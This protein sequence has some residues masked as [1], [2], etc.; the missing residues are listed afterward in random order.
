MLK[1]YEE[2]IESG[3][4]KLCGSQRCDSSPKMVGSCGYYHS[5]IGEKKS[6][7]VSYA[8]EESFA[9]AY[10]LMVQERNFILSS[11]YTNYVRDGQSISKADLLAAY[12]V[13]IKLLESKLYL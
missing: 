6:S 9:F 3:A 5:F 11:K 4:C 8:S 1:S 7:V 10:K 2:F 13:V 12:S